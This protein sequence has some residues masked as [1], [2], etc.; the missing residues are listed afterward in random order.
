MRQ[1]IEDVYVGQRG[2]GVGSDAAQD[3]QTGNCSCKG[4][5]K[6][7]GF[8]RALMFEVLQCRAGAWT[9]ADDLLTH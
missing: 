9:V 5:S 6:K 8:L 7:L 2:L 3:T 4:S 1:K